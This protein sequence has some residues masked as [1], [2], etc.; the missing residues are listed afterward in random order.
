MI[1]AIEARE[2][3]PIT[4]EIV[5]VRGKLDTKSKDGTSMLHFTDGNSPARMVQW[6]AP[7][8]HS[9]FIH[10][11]LHLGKGWQG[12]DGCCKCKTNLLAEL[13]SH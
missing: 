9:Q 2:K 11:H 4:G 7:Y 12:T 8:S 5:I 1:G 3:I 6:F 13:S 10:I